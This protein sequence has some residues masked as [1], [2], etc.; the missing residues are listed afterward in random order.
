MTL[1]HMLDLKIPNKRVSDLLIPGLTTIDAPVFHALCATLADTCQH[2]YS[3]ETFCC[4][5]P[6]I[7]IRGEESDYRLL[8]AASRELAEIFDFSEDALT[9]YDRIAGLF[10]RM[11]DTFGRDP[12]E[13][14]DFWRAIFT[15]KNVGSG[16]QL[17][18]DGW[19]RDFFTKRPARL[20]SF[21]TA[22]ASVPYTNL[23]T[24]KEFLSLVGAFTAFQDSEGFWRMNFQE[25]VFA[26]I[27][28][29]DEEP[30]AV[31]YGYNYET[32]EKTIHYSNGTKKIVKFTQ[33][34]NKD[35]GTEKKRAEAVSQWTIQELPAVSISAPQARGIVVDDNGSLAIAEAIEAVMLKEDNGSR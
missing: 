29:E 20:E 27:A 35:Q 1:A 16:R 13:S 19:I 26:K 9:Y 4:G 32:G 10:D 21:D 28:K 18:I 24:Q 31:S 23:E 12:E 22:I 7:K 14:A 11:A 17:D 25:A 2:Y 3:Y 30:V 5:I 8:A 6:K 33:P 15:Q 34:S